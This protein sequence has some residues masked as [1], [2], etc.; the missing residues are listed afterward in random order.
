MKKCFVITAP[1]V[2]DTGVVSFK[3]MFDSKAPRDY[4]SFKTWGIFRKSKRPDGAIN[5]FALADCMA[6]REPSGPVDISGEA[7]IE[8]FLFQ[9]G[10]GQVLGGSADVGPEAIDRLM[11]DADNACLLVERSFFDEIEQSCQR[12][13]IQLGVHHCEIS[14]ATS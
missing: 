10:K 7:C 11:D 8:M 3:F 5:P 13:G 4:L 14:L 1:E 12:L 9:G 2:R 6:R